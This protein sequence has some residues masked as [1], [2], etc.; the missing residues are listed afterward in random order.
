MRVAAAS[1]KTA[2]DNNGHG[3]GAE[4]R[5]EKQ[6][7][8]AH[9][10]NT[11]NAANA[12]NTANAG[13][14]GVGG[15]PKAVQP[16]GQV[17][18]GV[19]EK[20]ALVSK[21]EE[22]EMQKA[23][24]LFG[25]A[26]MRRVANMHAAA[27]GDRTRSGNDPQSDPLNSSAGAASLSSS[28]GARSLSESG[29]FRPA[30]KTTSM[31]S[32]TVPGAALGATPPVPEDALGEMAAGGG[33][34]DPG[35]RRDSLRHTPDSLSRKSLELNRA[36]GGAGAGATQAGG[37]EKPKPMMHDDSQIRAAIPFLPVPLAVL[38]LILN[39]L[40]PGSGL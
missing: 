20:G 13:T 15:K 9:V 24:A 6:R 21:E 33:G 26:V 12:A 11:A 37:E 36:A 38:C 39:I 3:L 25:K 23:H 40:I 35:T 27:G 31:Q 8:A 14:E 34:G 19:G 10:A 1:E 22:E 17:R 18:T 4:E 5:G 30:H 2:A 29:V 16:N 28:G 32:L 7:D